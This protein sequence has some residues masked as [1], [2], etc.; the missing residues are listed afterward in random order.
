MTRR[1]EEDFCPNPLSQARSE[2]GLCDACIALMEAGEVEDSQRFS[3]AE[4]KLAG[5]NRD[6]LRMMRAGNY[7]GLFELVKGIN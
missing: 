7:D 4:G 2:T 3:A 6:L 1:C 5:F